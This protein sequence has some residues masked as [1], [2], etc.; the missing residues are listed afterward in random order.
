MAMSTSGTTIAV[1]VQ[2]ESELNQ[3]SQLV[4][5]QEDGLLSYSPHTRVD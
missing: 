2:R 1:A 5:Y 3:M 4:F